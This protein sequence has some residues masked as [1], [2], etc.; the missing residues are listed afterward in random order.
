[1]SAERSPLP[2]GTFAAA[3]ILAAVTLLSAYSNS[4]NNSFHFDDM[5]VV[6][7][8]L[9]PQTREQRGGHV[10]AADEA[11][12]LCLHSVLSLTFQSAPIGKAAG[13][14]TSRIHCSIA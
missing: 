5:H 8:V 10:A 7:G 3:C 6:G 4:F 9:A 2:R 13:A 11:E 12:R 1:M 14:S